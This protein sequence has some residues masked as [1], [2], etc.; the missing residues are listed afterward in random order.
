MTNNLL[1]LNFM[2]SPMPQRTLNYQGA[3]VIYSLCCLTLIARFIWV[4]KTLLAIPYI[5][6]LYSSWHLAV[7]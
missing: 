5:M 4:V 3:C 2:N 1:I 7:Y 6:I